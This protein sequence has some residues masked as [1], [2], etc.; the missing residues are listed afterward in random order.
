MVS[1]L[2]I[3]EVLLIEHVASVLSKASAMLVAF[4]IALEMAVII[5]LN[6]CP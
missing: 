6:M 5:C 1:A 2:L 4:H 3:V